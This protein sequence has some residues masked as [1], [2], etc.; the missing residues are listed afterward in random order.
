MIFVKQIISHTGD[1]LY[2]RMI[3]LLSSDMLRYYLFSSEL[4]FYFLVLKYFR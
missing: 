4:Y 3:S 2:G 1:K